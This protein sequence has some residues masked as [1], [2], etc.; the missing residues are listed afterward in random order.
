MSNL[1][2]SND[3]LRVPTTQI[4]EGHF[5]SFSTTDSASFIESGSDPVHE[6][7]NVLTIT[8]VGKHNSVASFDTINS[9]VGISMSSPQS[10]LDVGGQTNITFNGDIA[11][12]GVTIISNT[13]IASN[14]NIGLASGTYNVYA[15][16]QGG[17][18]NGGAAGYLQGNL[19]L[20]SG[21]TLSASLLSGGSGIT[22]GSGLK[23][24]LSSAGVSLT[25]IFS[26]PGGGGGGA[27]G[28]QGGWYGSISG[29]PLPESGYSSNGLTGGTGGQVIY[30]NTMVTLTKP[31]SAE[32]YAISGKFLIPKGTTC[33]LPSGTVFTGKAGTYI[34][35][36]PNNTSTLVFKP[37]GPLS[38]ANVTIDGTIIDFINVPLN[39]QQNSNTVVTLNSFSYNYSDSTNTPTTTQSAATANVLGSTA[40]VT[41]GV[42]IQ[43]LPTT[44]NPIFA[45]LSSSVSSITR[46]LTSVGSNASITMTVLGGASNNVS[47]NTST[48][49]ATI[50]ET[51][52]VTFDKD[53]LITA[54]ATKPLQ[55]I[56]TNTYPLDSGTAFSVSQI[57][58]NGK[59]GSL[60]TGGAGDSISGGGG[61]G[62][63]GGGAGVSGGA[64]GAGSGY[65]NQ[66]NS[67]G[68]IF[69]AELSGGDK[70]NTLPDN[71]FNNSTVQYGWGGDNPKVP[72]IIIEKTYK[73]DEPLPA[74]TVNGLENVYGD[75][76][77]SGD[78]SI[79]QGPSGATFIVGTSG[80]RSSTILNGTLD[81]YNNVTIHN[82]SALNCGPINCSSFTT[83]GN[84]LFN[85]GA[86]VTVTGGLV[87]GSIT[88]PGGALFGYNG[89]FP[90]AINMP[91]GAILG[92]T[93]T[94]NSTTT[95]LTVY[96]NIS[97]NDVTATSDFRTKNNIVTIDS[98]L[99]RVMKMRGVFFERKNDP[100]ERC[101]G[102]IAQEVEEVLPEVVYTDENG[103]KSV[104][105]G[106]II[107]LLIEAI[108]EQQKTIMAL[109]DL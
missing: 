86:T 56:L 22:G 64:G 25:D 106:S 108:K 35:E 101:V 28:S 21:A 72:H 85:N 91:Y 24:S 55:S 67:S 19:S 46:F 38:I 60:N 58:V 107:G 17:Y 78:T 61:G 102:V 45:G 26:V 59:N 105:Y 20:S 11:T 49:T 109:K 79:L 50:G 65:I 75:L 82:N 40:S 57:S 62:F 66:L 2:L 12:R 93:A 81:V 13:G 84:S 54:P 39:I 53:I 89:T 97:G 71:R 31:V 42:Q 76:W 92:S 87:N 52:Q 95:L 73:L 30:G 96:G 3:I 41:S 51:T 80:G 27:A 43:V 47:V 5:L 103:M 9:R 16:G 100:G 15:W 90:S 63:F 74:L 83:T 14:T 8:N 34:V 69:S 18:G 48:N 77:V 1:S 23:F 32:L 6:A 7:G 4:N 10:T 33:V 44:T 104:S 36:N 94:P 37:Q 70:D 68:V 88:N 98:A 99:D 29:T